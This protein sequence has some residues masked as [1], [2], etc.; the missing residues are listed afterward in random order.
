M[1]NLMNG[2]IGMIETDELVTMMRKQAQKDMVAYKKAERVRQFG[3][4]KSNNGSA[5]SHSY[6]KLYPNMHQSGRSTNRS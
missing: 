4:D 2:P 5:K 6:T 3:I 1:T